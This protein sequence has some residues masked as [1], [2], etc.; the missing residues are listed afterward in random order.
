[1]TN[2]SQTL[3]STYLW[4]ILFFAS[5]SISAYV[6][7]PVPSGSKI[8]SQPKLLGPRAG[9]IR[10]CVCP[11][12]VIGSTSGPVCAVRWH[13]AEESDQLKCS[14][15]PENAGTMR[16]SVCPTNVIGSTSGPVCAVWANGSRDNSTFICLHFLSK[17]TCTFVRLEHAVHTYLA[18]RQRCTARRL[19]CPRTQLQGEEEHKGG[20]KHSHK[21]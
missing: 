1:M 18:C 14:E 6:C 7:P 13:E 15:G 11:T 16:P 2:S 21:W 19:T 4:L 20:L 12:N 17:H 3:N 9:T 8:G 5:A 10:P